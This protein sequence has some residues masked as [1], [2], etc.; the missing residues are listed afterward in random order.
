MKS[1]ST[2]PSVFLSFLAGGD[3]VAQPTYLTPEGLV[4]LKAELEALRTQ[5]R[6]AVAERIQKAKEIGG[7]VD[8]AEYDEAK[9][10]AGLHR[11]AHH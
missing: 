7:T 3:A 10:E 11:G 1:A 6:Q 9:N 2:G 4:T 5:R 8:N